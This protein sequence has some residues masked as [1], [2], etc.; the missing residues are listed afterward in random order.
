MSV[1]IF[2]KEGNTREER[3]VV[4]DDGS[5][6]FHDEATG[7]ALLR[8]APPARKTTLLPD[9]AKLRW[10]DYADKIDDALKKLG[11]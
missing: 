2:Q 7:Y 3:L 10:P 11:L 1:L 6:T 8:S 5:L 4:N 9:D